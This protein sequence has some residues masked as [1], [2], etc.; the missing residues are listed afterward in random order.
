MSADSLIQP[1]IV[2]LGVMSY[3]A[4]LEQQNFWHQKVAGGAHPVILTV[5]HQ[6]VLTLGKN[7]SLE[8]LLFS[9]EHYLNLGVE[10]FETERGG[11]VTAHMPGQL[12]VYPIIDVNKQKLSVRDYVNALESSV[13]DTLSFFGIPSARDPQW[14]GVWVCGAKICAIGVRVKSRVTMHGLA[15]NV[16][17]D[18]GLFGKIVPC[19]ISSRSVTSMS[20]FLGSKL[21]MPEVRNQLLQ[22]MMSRLYK[23]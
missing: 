3:G 20:N 18:L 16:N 13:I 9:R 5:E 8:H 15:L 2:D 21:A 6:P 11:E 19:G 12:V 17:N 14:P 10:L 7:A 22:S 1:E 23:V 4:A